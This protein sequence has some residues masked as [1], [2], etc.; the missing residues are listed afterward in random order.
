[1]HEKINSVNFNEYSRFNR[2]IGI[3]EDIGLKQN[4]YL[5][6]GQLSAAL[7]GNKSAQCN[8]AALPGTKQAK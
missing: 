2:F 3:C 7:Y 8:R 1:M 6:V 5:G 4:K